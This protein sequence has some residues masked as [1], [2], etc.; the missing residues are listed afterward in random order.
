MYKVRIWCAERLFYRVGKDF[1]SAYADA[2]TERMIID[3]M[4]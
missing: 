3:T 4:K 1:Q 2:V